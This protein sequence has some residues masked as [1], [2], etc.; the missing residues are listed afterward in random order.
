MEKRDPFHMRNALWELQMGD[1]KKA[2]MSKGRQQ[3]ILQG[4][5][6]LAV[7][8]KG[9]CMS[10]SFTNWLNHNMDVENTAE[11][12]FVHFSRIASKLMCNYT[13]ETIYEALLMQQFKCC[14]QPTEV[15]WRSPWSPIWSL[16]IIN[17]S[18]SWLTT[19]TIKKI[20]INMC[21]IGHKNLN[22]SEKIK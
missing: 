8:S 3:G 14:F 20:P 22:N 21:P 10:L 4:D 19:H 18:W 1:W 11:H 6:W 13:D 12:N 9:K 2:T 16:T 17:S 5:T 7:L 15:I